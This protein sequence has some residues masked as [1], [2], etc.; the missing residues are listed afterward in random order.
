M[1]APTTTVKWIYP[2][3]APIT[4]FHRRGIV[5]LTSVS[6]DNTVEDAIKV[7]RSTIM[8]TLGKLPTKII[9]EKIEY[10]L[11]NMEVKLYWEH[12]TGDETIAYLSAGRAS[13]EPVSGK[14][15]WRGN[16]NVPSTDPAAATDGDI[17][18]VTV[19]PSLG[20]TYNI[21]LHLRFKE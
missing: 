11:F 9:V 12:S 19:A 21:T 16:G 6:S 2:P 15:D 1:A 3:S 13:D 18:L 20:S 8:S 7:D 14:M 5:N 17:K 4:G 10:L